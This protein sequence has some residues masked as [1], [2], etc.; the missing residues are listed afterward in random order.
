MLRGQSIIA[1]GV[2]TA[3]LLILSSTLI[4]TVVVLIWNYKRRSAKQN[5]YTDTSY[6]TLSRQPIQPQSIQHN[7]AELYD[8]IHLS[9]STGQTEFIPKPQSEN[10][11]NPLHNS[12]PT[13]PDAENSMIHVSAASKTN[14][15]MA[16]YAAVDKSKKKVRK[17]NTKHTAAEKKQSPPVSPYTQRVSSTNA[18]NGAHAGGKDDL[19]VRS[20]KSLDDIYAFDH[21]DH[22][23]VSSEQEN[24]PPYTV[25]ELYTVVKKKPKGRSV[26]ENETVSHRAEDLYT[27]VM[28]KAEESSTEGEATPPHTVEELYTAVQK[29]AKGST[30][31]DEEEPPPIPPYMVEKKT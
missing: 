12:H 19:I 9:P 24:N 25:E 22:E 29:K 26:P 3:I 16:T 15:S 23:K 20:Q 27:A 31:K 1:I 11:N 5:L 30:M 18:D 4:I 10:I 28:K 14:S 2:S 21:K 6:T 7:S 17:E 13:H 8:Q